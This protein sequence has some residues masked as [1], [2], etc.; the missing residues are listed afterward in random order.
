MHT[1]FINAPMGR[2]SLNSLFAVPTT[3]SVLAHIKAFNSNHSAGETINNVYKLT[4]L[5]RAVQYLHA[6]A[7]FTTKSTWPKSISNGNYLTWPLITIHN[8]NRHFPESEETQKGHMRNQRQGVRSTKAKAPHLGTESP[9]EEK[10]RDVIMNVYE[11]KGNMYTYQ[12][13]NSSHRSIRLNRYQMILHENDG[14]ST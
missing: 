12:T 6:A 4:I 1:L 2:E 9:P 3:A 14:N 5:A 11:T 8:V 7:G 13:G 10:K